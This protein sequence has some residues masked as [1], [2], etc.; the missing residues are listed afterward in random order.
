MMTR[1]SKYYHDTMADPIAREYYLMRQREWMR[2]TY[3]RNG[4]YRRRKL[5][6]SRDRYRAYVEAQRAK[7]PPDP[8]RIKAAR[9]AAGFTIRDTA[10]LLGIKHQGVLAIEH[11]NRVA[12]IPADILQRLADAYNCDLAA[13]Y[14][15]GD[16][17]P[18]G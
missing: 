1:S 13:F 6:A 12:P 16:K 11:R 9:I 2:K 15:T 7:N 8:E 4:D 17:L 5:Q 10:A 18:D 3:H 14:K